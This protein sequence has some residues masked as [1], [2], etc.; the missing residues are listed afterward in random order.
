MVQFAGTER[1]SARCLTHLWWSKKEAFMQNPLQITF[2]DI[3]KSDEIEDLIGEKYARIEEENPNVTKCHVII[4]KMSKH[5]QKG[6][7]A[8]VRLDIKIPHFDD[9]VTKEDCLVDKAAIK[10]AVIKVFKH[11]LDLARE[12]KKRRFNN[13]RMPL[14]EVTAVDVVVDT[15]EE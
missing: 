13:K 2:H 4:E 12:H 3:D 9:V 5:H 10:S 7:Q 15:D 8:C 1:I 14:G 6:N 11:G